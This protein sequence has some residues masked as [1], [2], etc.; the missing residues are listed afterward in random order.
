M[1]TLQTHDCGVKITLRDW[2]IRFF[3]NMLEKKLL[4]TLR[5][6]KFIKTRKK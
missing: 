3:H 4:Q 6:E 1:P 5:M 2:F